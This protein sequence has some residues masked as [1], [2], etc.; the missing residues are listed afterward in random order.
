M[1]SP[2]PV[3]A[4]HNA[5]RAFIE[6]LETQLRAASP[7]ATVH[8]ASGRKYDKVRVLGDSA[9]GD[10]GTVTRYFI[11]R[12]T[13]AIYG[14]KS[15]AAPS[16]DHWYGTIYDADEWDW[17][18]MY[19]TPRPGARAEETSRYGTIIRYRPKDF[20]GGVPKDY[21]G[22]LMEKYMNSNVAGE[23]DVGVPRRC[24]P[25]TEPPR[26][27][28]RKPAPLPDSYWL[29][30]GRVAA[31][32]YP[33]DLDLQKARSKLHKL[34]DAGI[35]SFVDLT[36][37]RDG[38]RS[39]ERLLTKEAAARSL[40]VRYAPFGICDEDVPTP[41]HMRSLLA[42]VRKEADAGRPVYF[43]C[44]GGVGRTGTVAGC[45]LVDHG[46]DGAEAL[47]RV[48][49]LFCT[50][51]PER[52]RKHAGA[53][54]HTQAQRQFI[55]NWAR[56]SSAAKAVDAPAALAPEPLDRREFDTARLMVEHP[57]VLSNANKK[58]VYAIACPPG[59]VHAG[60]LHY[61]RWAAMQLP[62][63]FDPAL[64][65]HGEARTGFFDYPPS[66][67]STTDWH[68]NFA[69]PELFAFYGGHHFAQDEMQVA[70]HPALGA[71]REALQASRLPAR[72]L[73]GDQPAPVLIAGV[74]RRC[75]VSTNADTANGRGGG[76]Y[77]NAF[78][79]AP[80]DV[81]R[82]ATQ[83]HDP[84][85][86]SNIIAIAAPRSNGRYTR[87]QVESVL[88]TAYTGFRAAT[89]ESARLHGS[90][91]VA[92]HTGFWGCGA[93]GGNRVLMLALQMAAARMAEIDRL[94][95]YIGSASALSFV[96][97][98]QEFIS[99]VR[100]RSPGEFVAEVVAHGFEW[101]VGD[102]N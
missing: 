25:F 94:V 27:S 12:G 64:A 91:A 40:D 85:T 44:W 43:H 33:G 98:A 51:S 90:C 61:S 22:S 20:P 73:D 52:V 6:M 21:P 46:C 95:L 49:S 101:G 102:G 62:D 60:R 8:L 19:A 57:P 78:G 79:R 72:T 69:D 24:I 45:F 53:S 38:L 23:R 81:V 5:A 2:E 100:A 48:T 10:A 80:A 16:T 29:S 28:V 68:V 39:Y 99:A 4:Y 26:D 41:E 9:N 75:T 93:F 96:H 14:P 56:H 36:E 88:R 76:L 32:V 65:P 97:Q 67:G 42:H 83:R 86:I 13:G 18:G 30:P 17:S 89:I 82:R 77:G 7:D 66:R 70:E 34:L 15:P 92:V 63:A 11:D 54:P 3:P 87:Q 31:G 47:R 35:R 1:T 55:A 59:A 74:E 50:M 37:P 58:V 84:P 71:L